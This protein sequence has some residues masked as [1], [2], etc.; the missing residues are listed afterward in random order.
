MCFSHREFSL[1]SVTSKLSTSIDFLFFRNFN[2]ATNELRFALAVA[3]LR[4]MPEHYHVYQV[5]TIVLLPNIRAVF[6]FLD[7]SALRTGL[8]GNGMLEKYVS[9]LCFMLADLGHRKRV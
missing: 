2:A 3:A 9:F 4:L 8:L 6:D 5:P 7:R 1:I